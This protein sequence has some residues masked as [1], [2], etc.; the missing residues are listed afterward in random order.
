MAS[1]GG[2]DTSQEYKKHSIFEQLSLN[3]AK[4]TD[5]LTKLL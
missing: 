2:S 4:V 3:N 5:N 1:S